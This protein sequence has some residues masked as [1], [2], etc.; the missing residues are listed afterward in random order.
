VKLNKFANPAMLALLASKIHAVKEN[1]PTK[2]DS[3]LARRRLQA[4]FQSPIAPTSRNVKTTHTPLEVRT[5][6]LHAMARSTQLKAHHTAIFAHSTWNMTK[7]NK[8]VFA[9]PLLSQLATNAH[10]LPAKRLLMRNVRNAKMGNTKVRKASGAVLHA[11]MYTPMLLSPMKRKG[12]QK[13]HAHVARTS[14]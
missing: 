3:S 6:V 7:R 4:T 2:R 13:I 8:N 11:M 14:F 5:S 12:Y 9:K 1:I 10:A